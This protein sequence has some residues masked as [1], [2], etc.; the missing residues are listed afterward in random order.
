[1]KL[2]KVTPSKVLKYIV[3]AFFAIVFM[4]PIWWVIVSSF[5]RDQSIFAA[6]MPFSGKALWFDVE[7]RDSPLVA[8]N[9]CIQ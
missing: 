7:M 8:V 2:A 9:N 1:M 3:L 6:L 5:K 4:L